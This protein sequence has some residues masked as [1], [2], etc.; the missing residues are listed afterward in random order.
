MIKNLFRQHGGWLTGLIL[1]L[2]AFLLV[3]PVNIVDPANI[4]WL[5]IHEDTRTYFL[6]WDF[7][8]R[9]PW[10]YPISANPYYGM[11]IAGSIFMTDT[12]PLLAIPLKAFDAVLPTIFQ[13]H[14]YGCWDVFCCRGCWAGDWHHLLPMSFGSEA[15]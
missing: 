15:V 13:Y 7:F 11:D 10:Q 6:G 5:G 14:E 3:I 1:G 12:I 8:R 2:V 9:S 4:G